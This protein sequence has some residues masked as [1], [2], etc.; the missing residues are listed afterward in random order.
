MGEETGRCKMIMMNIC[1]SFAEE[2]MLNLNSIIDDGL[3]R[4]DGRRLDDRNHHDVSGENEIS[5]E[6]VPSV[7]RRTSLLR[8]LRPA[9]HCSQEPYCLL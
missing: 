8:P 4:D 6:V 2:L 1:N 3:N 9:S 5:S 7:F